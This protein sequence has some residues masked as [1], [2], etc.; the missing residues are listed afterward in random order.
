MKAIVLEQAGGSD[1]LLYKEVEK[2]ELKQVK[3]C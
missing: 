1:K 2:P 3:F